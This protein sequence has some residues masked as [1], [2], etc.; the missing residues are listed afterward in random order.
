LTAI[1]RTHALNPGGRPLALTVVFAPTFAGGE[2]FE[3]PCV[4]PAETM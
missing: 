1:T 2:I 4:D 3:P